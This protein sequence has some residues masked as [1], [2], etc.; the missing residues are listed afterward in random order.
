MIKRTELCGF[1]TGNEPELNTE[2]A[3]IYGTCRRD[4][5]SRFLPISNWI[6]FS[7]WVD[8]IKAA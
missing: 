5:G 6:L 4:G 1:S 3:C 8:N 2:V 7:N